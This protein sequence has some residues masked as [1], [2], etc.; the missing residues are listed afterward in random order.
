VHKGLKQCKDSTPENLVSS[1]LKAVAKAIS[2]PP[3]YDPPPQRYT[4]SAGQLSGSIFFMMA[5][6]VL[7]NALH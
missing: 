5:G 6:A 2:C 3:I 4:G 7:V 1:M